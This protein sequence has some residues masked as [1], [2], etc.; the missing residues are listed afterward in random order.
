MTLFVGSLHLGLIYG[1]M[2]LGITITFRILNTP[3]LTTDGSF[4]LGMAVSA[5]FAVMG[6][7]GW[8]ILAGIFAGAAAGTVTGLLQTLLG[9]HPI[10]SGILAM[11]GLYSINLYALGVRSNVSLLGTQHLFTKAVALLPYVNK[12]IVRLMVAFM[13]CAA[14]FAVLVWFF[15]THLGLCIRAAGDNDDMVKASSINVNLVRVIAIAVSNA[16]V[17]LSGAVAAQYQGYADIGSGGGMMVVGLASVIIGDMFFA[18][19]N[20]HSVTAGFGA[21]VCGSVV[22]RLIVALALKSNVFPSYALKLVSALIVMAALA[23]P[24]VKARIRLARKKGFSKRGG[25]S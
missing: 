20:I 5:S 17:G 15:R 14:C 19:L 2:A 18:G 9:I 13:F 16:C 11:S 1:L 10:L 3:D 6:M 25:L 22:Y 24:A 12:D 23:L 4:T 21:A 7:P 8:G